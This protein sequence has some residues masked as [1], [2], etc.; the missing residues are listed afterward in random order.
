MLRR[1]FASVLIAALA[2]VTVLPAFAQDGASNGA[3]QAKSVYM[4]LV[5]GGA[6]NGVEQDFTDS[7]LAA[8]EDTS[9]T[10][11]LSNFTHPCDRWLLKKSQ[12]RNEV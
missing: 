6:A 8:D 4:P 5:T 9:F 1:M 3:D 12:Q 10:P 2:L 7:E 11:A